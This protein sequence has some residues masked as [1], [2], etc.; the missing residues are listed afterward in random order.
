MRSFIDSMPFWI[1]GSTNA[2]SNTQITDVIADN[3][4]TI[5]IR[6]Y[7]K[8]IRHNIKLKKCNKYLICNLSKIE[9]PLFYYLLIIVTE[10]IEW[11]RSENFST[12]G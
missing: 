2:E 9:P 5:T 11:F 8:Y 12:Y 7:L 10:Q 6:T 4:G 1:G 3:S